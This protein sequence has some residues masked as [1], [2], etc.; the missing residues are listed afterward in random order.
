MKQADKKQNYMREAE[1]L[2]LAELPHLSGQFGDIWDGLNYMFL[3]RVPVRE[4]AQKI[5]DSR[6]RLPTPSLDVP[7][8]SLL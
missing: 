5:I 6:K 7:D 1:R 2:I 3:T 8:K 4:A